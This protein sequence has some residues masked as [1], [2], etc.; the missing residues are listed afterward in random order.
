[1]KAEPIPLGPTNTNTDLDW[2]EFLE[3]L[4]NVLETMCTHMHTHDVRSAGYRWVNEN[5]AGTGSS[6]EHALYI[7][8]I[9]Q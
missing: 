1:M 4:A 7:A 3:V 5:T 9:V 2:E 6:A 8:I